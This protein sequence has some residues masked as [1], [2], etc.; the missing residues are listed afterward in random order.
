MDPDDPAF[1]AMPSM[2][3]SFSGTHG[4]D[5][6]PLGEEQDDETEFDHDV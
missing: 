5:A 4:G 6:S 3:L 2:P 1:N